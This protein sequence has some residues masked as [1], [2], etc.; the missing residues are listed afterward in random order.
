MN[1]FR[2]L[3]G[4]NALMS[5][6]PV[7]FFFIGLSDG[8]IDGDNIGIWMLILG[9]VGL[10]LGGTYW[11]KTKNQLF[12]AKIILIISSIPSLIAILYMG[13]IIFGDVRWN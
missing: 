8:S 4:F 2:I 7:S 6:I 11:L 1:G 9:A 5:L 12:L 13:M 3:W 10:I